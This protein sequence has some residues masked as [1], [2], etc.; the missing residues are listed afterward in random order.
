[1]PPGLRVRPRNNPERGA[2]LAHRVAGL[3]LLAYFTVHA[4]TMG[5]ALAG[6]SWAQ[7]AAFSLAYNPWVRFVVGSAAVFHGLNGLRLIAVEALGLGVGRP[8]I[9][10]PPYISGSLRAG[11]RL[12]LHAVVVASAAAMAFMAYALLAWG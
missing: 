10:R 12:A 11:Q 4:V 1:M 8:G 6:A 7:G 3:I 2:H 9:P 5:A